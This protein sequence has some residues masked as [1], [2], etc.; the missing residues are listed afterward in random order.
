VRLSAISIKANEPTSGQ[1]DG[2]NPQQAPGQLLTLDVE[3]IQKLAEKCSSPKSTDK[4]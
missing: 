2:I 4:K 3:N 1:E